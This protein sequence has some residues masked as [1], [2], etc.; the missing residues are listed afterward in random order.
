MPGCL[1]NHCSFYV[2]TFGIFP[3]HTLYPLM[4]RVT[5][6]P[7]AWLGLAMNWGLP[8]AWLIA[9]PTDVKSPPMWVLTFG[10]LWCVSILVSVSTH[11]SNA[12]VHQLDHCI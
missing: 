9:S 8:T 11:I 4:K 12:R 3:L 1:M 7:Q 10:A 6:W 2:G 5:M